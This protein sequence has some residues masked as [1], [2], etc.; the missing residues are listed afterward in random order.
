[1]FQGVWKLISPMLDPVV[2]A[3]VQFT[4]KTVLNPP[5]FLFCFSYLD[6]DPVRNQSDLA[7]HID[8][9]H[10]IRKLGGTNDWQ[11][12]YTKVVPGENELLKDSATREVKQLDYP[13]SVGSN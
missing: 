3:K 5:F 6:S 9:R 7:V 4:K 1:V 13:R 2:R 12:K 11:W 10:L 8:R